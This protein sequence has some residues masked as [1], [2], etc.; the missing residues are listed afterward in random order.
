M[1]KLTS[2]N[3]SQNNAIPSKCQTGFRYFEM[4]KDSLYELDETNYIHF[5]YVIEGEL[6]TGG[7][8]HSKPVI[9]KGE[10]I[11]IPET[12]I[13]LMSNKKTKFILFSIN[14]YYCRLDP[15]FNRYVSSIIKGIH[16]QP[17]PIMAPVSLKAFYT[18]IIVLWGK[19]LD[20]PIV[21]EIK[22]KELIV[23]L[24][25]LFSTENEKVDG[26]YDQW[27]YGELSLS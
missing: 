7:L 4:K 1:F 3:G 10:F 12:R 24:D 11:L 19:K 2:Y 18:E 14:E 23:L 5:L 20:D 13:C 21:Q 8:K 22:R 17:S 6:M 26:S 25:Y 9:K 27:I 15:I 16:K